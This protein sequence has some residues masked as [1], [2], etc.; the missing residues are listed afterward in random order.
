[1]DLLYLL[2]NFYLILFP[3]HKLSI[4]LSVIFSFIAKDAETIRDL[5]NEPTYRLVYVV[6]AQALDERVPP[7]VLQMYGTNNTF[8]AI[9]VI[10]RWHFTK[11]E[12]QRFV[13]FYINYAR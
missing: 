1:M 3:A 12:L 5:I 4:K 11:T 6:M 10:H 7:F 9:D 13:I 2:G 8:R